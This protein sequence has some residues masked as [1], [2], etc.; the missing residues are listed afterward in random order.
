MKV[1]TEQLKDGTVMMT[2]EIV[3]NVVI[4]SW[5]RWV[6]CVL[7]NRETNRFRPGLYKVGNTIF[8]KSL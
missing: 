3:S 1:K 2:G 4:D 6:K 5:R 8:V 7:T